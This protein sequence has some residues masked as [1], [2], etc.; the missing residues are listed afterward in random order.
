MVR[1]QFSSRAFKLAVSA[2]AA[3][4][5]LVVAAGSVETR[6]RLE[7]QRRGPSQG[8]CTQ[9]DPELGWVTSPSCYDPVWGGLTHN[10]LGYRSPEVRPGVPTVAVIGDSVAW[11][12][13]VPDD[14][15]ATAGL[16]SL[17]DPLELQVQNL[18][19]PGFG[20][21]QDYLYLQEN[22]ERLP[23]L[24]WVILVVCSSN[25]FPDTR[26]NYAYSKRKPLW[27]PVGDDIALTGVPIDPD[28]RRNSLSTSPLF[29]WAWTRWWRADGKLA[30][31][32]GDRCLDEDVAWQ[33]I[34]SLMRRMRID[35][36]RRGAR[37][38][39]VAVPHEGAFG[40]E[41]DWDQRWKDACNRTGC[42]HLDFLGH[43]R[44]RHLTKPDILID[45]V[46]LNP[47][48]SRAL[49]EFLFDNGG[50][51]LQSEGG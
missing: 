48:G 16:Q 30:N 34:D 11:G 49:A 43:A 13:S 45:N 3:L 29:A 4:V 26:C 23:E 50:D 6:H 33:V 36:E 46:H 9:F 7:L 31:W 15:T 19:V 39:V 17:V 47:S 37:F 27:V 24:R 8:H 32:A 1:S 14:E 38:S 12:F 10:S 40:N 22:I 25:D 28:C 5:A 21:G 18:G 2:V 44:G 42:E 41:D 51:I 20:I 35:V